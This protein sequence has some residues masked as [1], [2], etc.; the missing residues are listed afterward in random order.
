MTH[1]P[2]GERCRRETLAGL[3]WGG[4]AVGSRIGAQRNT[5]ELAVELIFP[6]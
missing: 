2:S 5:R 1:S 6:L 4:V 3:P